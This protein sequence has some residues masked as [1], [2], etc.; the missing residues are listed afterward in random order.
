MN[1]TL[2]LLLT[3]A[4]VAIAPLTASAQ[5]VRVT[6]SVNPQKIYIGDTA[7][8]TITVHNAESQSQPVISGIPG[9]DVQFSNSSKNSSMSIINGRRSSSDTQNL[10]YQATPGRE[11]AFVIP[12]QSVVVDGK[13]YT[14]NQ[15]HFQVVEPPVSALSPLTI[16]PEKTTAYVGEPIRLN[17][18][19]T[20]GER[21]VSAFRFISA[22]TP[23]IEWTSGPQPRKTNNAR[24]LQWDTD[25][26]VGVLG[27]TMT[28]DGRVTTLSAERWFIPLS[29]GAISL[30]PITCIYDVETGSQPRSAFNRSR[31]ERRMTRSNATSINVLPLPLA[32]RPDDFD[33]L[34]GRYTALASATP[35]RVHVGDPITLTYEIRTDGPMG[36]IEPPDL[37][38]NPGIAE[39]F[40]LDSEGWEQ[41]RM[42]Q[43][44]VRRYTTTIRAIRDSIDGFPPLGFAYFDTG[45][46]EYRRAESNRIPLMVDATTEVTAADAISGGGDVPAIRGV[47]RTAL[48]DGPGGILA[49]AT[50]PD[51][52]INQQTLLLTRFEKPVWIAVFTAP[53][54]GY[55]ALLGVI[56]IR[57]STD[58]Q[59][60]R[61]DG[62]RSA[63][64][65]QLRKSNDPE[66]AIRTYLSM[67][68]DRNA[69][70][71]TEADCRSLLGDANAPIADELASAMLDGSA[72]RYGTEPAEP[73]SA[74]RIAELL[75]SIDKEIRR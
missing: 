22:D 26:L 33:G 19:W 45:E 44:G 29:P 54:I 59:A 43:P 74:T 37:L 24:D 4:L 13:A 18:T 7:T 58:P 27:E 25:M 30:G 35:L 36:R 63:A 32:G 48:G 46:G 20:V 47:E 70:A 50:S 51:A 72:G 52:L 71:I 55:F 16:E 69:E 3:L 11:G 75:R 6:A 9:L 21:G 34:V 28:S 14:T 2:Q 62:A 39:S 56:A 8:Y 57:R 15:V 68:F 60:R 42:N 31:P 65:T 1:R 66:R 23:G 67:R 10:L 73:P 38:N 61:R 40:K 64:L 17:A 41:V 53:P 5:A 49:N 12:A